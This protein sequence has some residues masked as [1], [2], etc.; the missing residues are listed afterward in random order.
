MSATSTQ[1]RS[2][3]NRLVQAAGTALRGLEQLEPRVLLSGVET[4][5]WYGRDVAVDSGSWIMT[6]EEYLGAGAADEAISILENTGT[7]YSS[8]EVLGR[9]KWVKIESEMGFTDMQAMVM[10]KHT[11]G[12]L[13]IEPD[14]VREA[15]RVPNDPQFGQQFYQQNT[16]QFAFPTGFGTSGADIGAVAAW[17]ITI[18]SPDV[19]VAVI[20]TGVDLDHPDLK[21]N[22]YVNLGEIP[23]N[24]FD[25]DGN[26]FIDD[27]NGWDFGAGDNDPNDEA[28]HGTAVA[29]TIAA[30][31]D[32]GIG[33]AGVGWNVKVLPIK[34]ANEFGQL[35]TAAI[36]S[37]HEYARTMVLAGHNIVASNNSYG[38]FAAD[39]FPATGFPA[40]EAAIQAFVDTGTT[41]VASAGNGGLDGIGDDNDQ[42]SVFPASYNIP[43]ILVVAATDNNDALTSFSNFG[44]SS[45]D[46]AAPG[47]AIYTT[48]MG[49]GY[50]WINGTSFSSPITA[51]AVALLK[52]ARPTASAIEIREALFASVDHLPSLQ[53]KVVS[54]GRLNVAE[55]LR[56]IG[57]D[58]PV[59]TQA[60]P[61]PVSLAP[62][63]N[64]RF[65]FNRAIDPAFVST[66]EVSILRAG[67]DGSFGEANDVVVGVASVTLD[68]AGT[69]ATILPAS[70]LPADLVRVT[71][72]PNGFRDKNGNLLNGN[73]VS[74]QAEVY[75]F[76]LVTVGVDLEPNDSLVT[77]T[78]V[79]FDTAG[80]AQFN[81]LNVGDGLFATRD[82]DLF[83]VQMP[84][85]GL[86]TAAVS[87]QNR[88]VPSTLDSYL[89]LFDANGVELA[90]NDQFNGSDSFVDFFVT[91]GGTYYVGVSGFPNSTY[92]PTIAGSGISSSRGLY[93]LTITTD[94]VENDRRTFSS[95][96]TTPVP[97]PDPGVVT[98]TITISDTREIL[99][100]NLLLNL[101]H[102]F[103]GDLRVTLTSPTGTE[104]VVMDGN[105][106]NGDFQVDPLTPVPAV[107][108]D[109][110]SLAV[111]TAPAPF[112]SKLLQPF[113]ALS[114]FDGQSAAGTWTLRV[115]DTNSLNSG[116]LIGWSLE[117]TVLT[118]IF[119]PF[120]SNDTISTAR[121]LGEING[122]G[123][124]TRAAFIGDGGFGTLDVDLYQFV[125]DAGATL[126]VTSTS[127]G[128]VDTA[129]RL[130]DSTGTEIK[131]SNP[132][133]QLNSS[134]EDYVFPSGGTFY[135]GVSETNNVEGTGAY[136]PTA[137]ASGTAAVSTGSYNL[138]VSVAPGVSDGEVLLEGSNLTLGLSESGAFGTGQTGLVFNGVEFLFSSSSPSF[139]NAYYGASADGI[140]FR[141]DGPGF[142]ADLPMNIEVGSDTNN[143][144]V[145]TRGVFRGL[146]VERT[147]SFGIDDNFVAVDVT[148]T[149]ASGSAKA[150]VAWMD[151]FN[152]EMGLNLVPLSSNTTNDVLDGSPYV[153]ASFSNAV[154]QNGLTMA[155]GAAQS[156][157]RAT[158]AAVDATTFIRDAR[159]LLDLGTVDPN[160]LNADDVLSISYDL[161]A[162]LAGES[163]SMRYFFFLGN[164]QADAMA[165]YNQVNAGTGQGHLAANASTPANDT[166][167]VATLPFIVHYPE[168]YANN[169]ATTTI[170]I[171]NT[172]E[173]ASRV[174]VMARYETGVRDQ[175]LYDSLTDDLDGDNQ[176]DGLIAPNTRL[177]L[178]I[179]SPTSY[180][181]G[182][183]TN[184][185]S[186]VGG[187]LGVRKDAPFALEIRSSE[188]IAAE[189]NHQDFGV[190]TGE[191]FTSASA[192][193]W[194]FPTVTKGGDSSDFIVFY[195]DSDQT[196]KI[197]TALYPDGG[198]SAI[199]LT[200]DI[201][202][203]RRAG[204]NLNAQSD[205]LIPDGT[206]GVVVSSAQNLVAA[207]SSYDPVRGAYTSLGTPGLGSRF[208]AT[209]EGQFGLNATQEGLAI[210]NATATTAEV[211]LVFSFSNGSAYR[212]SVTVLNGSR[213]TLDVSQLPG[214]PAGLPYSISFSSN[215][216]VSLALPSQGFGEFA[217]TSFSDSGHTFWGFADG[218][219]PAGTSANVAEY[220]R[221]YNPGIQ[222][223]V[224]EIELRFVDGS[225][226]VFR[227][228]AG[229]RRV[230]EFN[231]HDFISGSRLNTDQVYGLTVKT[232]TPV[233][234]YMARS[235]TA[236][237]TGSF[238]T[239]GTPLGVTSLLS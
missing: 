131:F 139:G 54:G 123:S 37:A 120:E 88:P 20:D 68:A 174:I 214:F 84:R 85:G 22:I 74:G 27:V 31:G 160:G 152:P 219:R 142:E 198:G 34:I 223:V 224:V 55:A 2:R 153:S 112:G 203:R 75:T 73:A 110:A 69:T 154:F 192:T 60:S 29:G 232:A 195:N 89:R 86:I 4:I 66:A 70:I 211:N 58:G 129:L 104:I 222:D 176:P 228:S 212:E 235:D 42:F 98:D 97:I 163:T 48:A 134:I 24:G 169:R 8:V 181:A 90:S 130:F 30:V 65:T 14:R 132:S 183:A 200:Q 32:N 50:Q 114:G 206:Y 21:D 87:A 137:A 143:R 213:T 221:V 115:E 199:L 80:K 92:D 108:D 102:D 118:N 226:E 148:L 149:N 96:L 17:D 168:G 185:A 64:L 157:S 237:S 33:I 3:H 196:V 77:A 204:W 170:P 188:P 167:G 39:F 83:R 178:P 111:A 175:I 106:G 140:G 161:G 101:N 122:S 46:I 180:A 107:F 28:G 5:E 162:I 18:G 79:T 229:A 150:D 234:A 36:I 121:V 52:S 135:I 171:V 238:G 100:V 159:Q 7:S 239:L 173:R 146:Q 45:V 126:N 56:V 44:A 172:S 26:G 236:F 227:G 231:V 201:G 215:T 210:L 164:T 133:G 141:N 209:P 82:V 78:P 151:A 124:A 197:T 155:I 16:G 225:T 128:A 103:V 205:T 233:V 38:S 218:F 41:F 15:S 125:V 6:F 67:G 63:T 184:V 105:G 189:M 119:G 136:D 145:T 57:L 230:A 10:A 91:T 35:T 94:L 59:V 187:R 193:A 23:G 99:D 12:L 191:A 72:N 51:G 95:S 1:N 9:G 217:T 13:A 165:L 158:V 49:G 220:L 207:V 127:Q 43:Q 202:P 11:R 166:L 179:N 208:G 93:D 25:D 147:L 156:E 62:A 53:G 19:V 81:G 47:E 138:S 144:R 182:S 117:V 109:E 76:E 194:S 116:V 216:E 61:G 186:S 177:T 40:E 190:S 71:L 113:A